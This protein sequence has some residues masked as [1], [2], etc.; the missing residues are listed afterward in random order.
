M[1]AIV[2]RVK[3]LTVILETPRYIPNALV[4]GGDQ[5]ALAAG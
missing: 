4:I 5:P 1:L 3:A 2:N